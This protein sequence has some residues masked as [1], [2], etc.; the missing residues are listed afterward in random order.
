MSVRIGVYDFFAYTIPGVLY[1]GIILFALAIFGVVP[2]TWNSLNDVSFAGLIFLVGAGYAL[3]M[4]LDVIAEQWSYLF[5]KR[6]TPY[7]ML[8]K[9]A[10]LHQSIQCN[11]SAND[12]ILLLASIRQASPESAVDA[13]QHNA[14]SIMLRN[15]SLAF[16]L[17]AIVFLLYFVVVA[18][19]YWNIGFALLCLIASYL[20][21]RRST[22]RREW[23]YES[24]YQAMA[25]LNLRS[26]A[27]FTVRSTPDTPEQSAAEDVVEAASE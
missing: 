7:L 8:E 3:G 17:L 14:I 24:V 15:L 23:F 6:K 5:R 1:L 11:F 10:H 12:W 9:F 13:E 27:W 20:A 19:N 2:L 22:M 25:A 21:I 16:L 26:Y 4:L 18:G